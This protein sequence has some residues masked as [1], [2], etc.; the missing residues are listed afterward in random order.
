MNC[1]SCPISIDL[2]KINPS[3]RDVETYE[4]GMRIAMDSVLNKG[5]SILHSVKNSVAI[6]KLAAARR[7][8]LVRHPGVGPVFFDAPKIGS[9]PLNVTGQ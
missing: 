5:T 4:M 8:Y 6:R 9:G 2:R 1:I 3:A 7:E